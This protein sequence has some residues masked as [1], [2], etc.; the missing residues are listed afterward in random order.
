M[1]LSEVGAILGR[2]MLKTCSTC[3]RTM[4]LDA[5]S[6]RAA[7]ADGRQN[8]CREC[9]RADYAANREARLITSAASTQARLQ[10]H[11]QRLQ[12][13]LEAHP[14]VDCGEA[15][16][17]CLDFDHRDPDAKVANVGA[18]VA[19]HVRW[20]RI[21]A[22]IDKCDVRCANCHRRRTSE[23]RGDWRQRQW[24]LDA[25]RIGERSRARLRLIMGE[26]G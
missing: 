5:F 13:Y 15:D 14:C 9:C 10:S 21:Q 12:I 25:Q 4:P 18:L 1:E 23:Q 8:R 16:I 20:S 26:V 22:E 17:R 7:S 3:R 6:R 2:M 19:M 24:E 11:R